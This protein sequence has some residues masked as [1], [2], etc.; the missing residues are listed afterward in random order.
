M[1]AWLD[2]AAVW[3]AVLSLSLHSG[4]GWRGDG[5]RVE[6]GV[7]RGLEYDKGCDGNRP[8]IFPPPGI[9]HSVGRVPA[10]SYL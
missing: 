5:P 7:R 3:V 4:E 2:T 1:A 10:E 8:P 6:Q 9:Q